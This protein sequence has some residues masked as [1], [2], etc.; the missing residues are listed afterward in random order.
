MDKKQNSNV[1]TFGF[2]VMVAAAGYYSN[3]PVCSI[4]SSCDNLKYFIT[5][6]FG[7]DT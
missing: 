7:F 1:W 5:V 4:E 3:A 2:E 6:C